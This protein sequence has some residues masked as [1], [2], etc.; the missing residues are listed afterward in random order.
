MI[1]SGDP[2]FQHS[3]SAN[4][5]GDDTG[6]ARSHLRIVDPPS[7]RE[8]PVSQIT[9]RRRV[10]L[11]LDATVYEQRF[12]DIL[13]TARA[14]SGV[15]LT[16]I[17]TATR[18]SVP[19]LESLEEMQWNGLPSIAYAA[20]YAKSY[21]AFLGLDH[22]VMGAR[23]EAGLASLRAPKPHEAAAAEREAV[24]AVGLIPK[25]LVISALVGAVGASA[26]GIAALLAGQP[27][28]APNNVHLIAAPSAFNHQ[29]VELDAPF[30]PSPVL[31][32]LA[33]RP[34]WLEVRGADGTIFLSRRLQAGEFY[35]AQAFAGWTLHAQ[36]GGAFTVIINGAETGPLGTAG[37]PVINWRVD[38]AIARQQDASA[39]AQAAQTETSPAL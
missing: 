39:A 16:E 24:K 4:V 13:K 7:V 33:I 6:G 10:R 29:A 34:A 20:G 31:A 27:R 12:G 3:A 25:P 21:C 28:A 9:L 14:A 5:S 30:V 18:L 1:E 11:I 2:A 8:A 26:L 37:A 23:L 35:T 32:V 17:A 22:S 15:P 38:E 36:D 19:V